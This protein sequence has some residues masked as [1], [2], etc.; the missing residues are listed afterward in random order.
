MSL[1]KN[2]RSMCNLICVI[3]LVAII[4]IQ[5]CVPFYKYYGTIKVNKKNTDA[6]L[7][8]SYGSVVWFPKEDGYKSLIDGFKK[9]DMFG[10]VNKYGEEY[11]KVNN[12]KLKFNPD[13]LGYPHFYTV[14]LTG[15]SLALFLLKRKSFVPSALSLAA[16]IITTKAFLTNRTIVLGP[17][18]AHRAVSDQN[19]CLINVILGILVICVA[20]FSLFGGF[21]VEPLSKKMAAKK[22][23]K[24]AAK[25]E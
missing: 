14:V 8:A 5:L 6:V 22:A 3:L 20:L 1:V 25:A 2:R 4:V 23:A 7:T 24:A 11:G 19:V 16:G 18:Y 17:Q 12:R 9:D 10:S 21:I 13:E 15:F